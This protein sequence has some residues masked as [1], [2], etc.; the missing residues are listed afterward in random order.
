MLVTCASWWWRGRGI[1]S[2]FVRIR[3]SKGELIEHQV[4]GA[5]SSPAAGCVD[6]V[7]YLRLSVPV[8]VV[9]LRVVIV[10]RSGAYG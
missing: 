3:A 10:L 1:V 2:Y 8:A 7:G 5:L 6:A 9:A 4:E